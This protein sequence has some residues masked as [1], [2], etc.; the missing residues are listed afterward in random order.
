LYS[1]DRTRWNERYLVGEGPTRVNARLRTYLRLLK[2]GRALDLAG[3]LGQNSQLLAEWDTILIDISEQAL[4]RAGG[5]R[6]QADATSLPFPPNT[7]DTII[8]TYFFEPR[9]N[10]F[11]LLTPGGTLFFETYTL[12]DAKY[13]LDFNP[14]HRFNPADISS[15]FKGLKV[16]HWTE[17]D[18]GV[19][20]FG[21]LIAR[22]P[23]E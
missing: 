17:T 15:I 10:F 22:K 8:C 3:G 18:D 20:V 6:V 4:T 1:D 16:L 21:T 5:N 7:F 12:A 2:R 11:E 13:R 9:V 14:A 23:P 19:R